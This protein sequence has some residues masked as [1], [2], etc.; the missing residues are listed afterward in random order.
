VFLL[1][2]MVGPLSCPREDELSQTKDELSASAGDG[3]FTSRTP[4]GPFAF[5]QPGKGEPRS[6]CHRWAGLL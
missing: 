3:T 5:T 4:S 6:G 2:I 1:A